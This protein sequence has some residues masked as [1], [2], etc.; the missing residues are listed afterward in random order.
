MS[1]DGEPLDR[2]KTAYYLVGVDGARFRA[3]V[4]PGDQLVLKSKLIV[5]A[6]QSVSTLLRL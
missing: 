3:P 4:V 1:E 5:L 2:E 6:K